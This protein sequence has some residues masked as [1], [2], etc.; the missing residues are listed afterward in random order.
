MLLRTRSSRFG[1]QR[2]WIRPS[3]PTYRLRRR[4]PNLVG[5]V[6]TCRQ[7]AG[8]RPQ[9]VLGGRGSKPWAG[10]AALT[11]VC[12]FRPRVVAAFGLWLMVALA[13]P[14]LLVQAAVPQ[15]GYAALRAGDV[16]GALTQFRAALET[17]PDDLKALNMVGAVLCMRN[18]TEASIPYFERALSIAPEFVAA[19]KNLAM[20]EFDLG[21]HDSAKRHLLQLLEVEDAR[22][23]ASLFLGM[24]ASEDGQHE[25]AIQRFGAAESLLKA[26]PRAA[27]SYARS[28]HRLGHADRMSEVLGPVLGRADLTAPDLVDLAQLYASAAMFDESLDALDRAEAAGIA[29]AGLAGQRLDVLLAAGREAQA[30]SHARHAVE[31]EPSQDLLLRLARLEESAGDLD[32]AVVALRRAIQADPGSEAGYIE[33]SEFCIRYRNPGLA[34]EILDLGL[35]RMPGSYRLFVQKGITLGQ[36]QR[37]Q[38]ARQAFSEAIALTADHSVALTAMAVA[39]LLSEETDLALDTLGHGVARFPDDFYVNY[40]YGFALERSQAADHESDA[41]ARAELHLRK[42]IELNGEFPSARYRLGK[43]LAENSPQEAI[44]H[45]EA[46]V[47]LAPSLDAAK[48]QLGQIY[49]SVGRVEEGERLI[50]EVGE[51][52]QRDLEAE[53]MPQFRAFKPPPEG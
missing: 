6:H 27:I 32:A 23:Q 31:V 20:A 44:Q 12:A 4:L 46:A 39:L 51:A 16:D 15:D 3:A 45:L 30:L 36:A 53:Q 28:L 14:G 18:E 22:A 52:K 1:N 41:L 33:L 2:R 42:S 37:Y 48:Y 47:R 43:I 34:L 21:R 25:E 50:R 26:Q 24:I 35:N 40:V 49:I 19:R 9:G 38:E 11:V 7:L 17:N 5:A 8:A 10:C 29:I 13:G